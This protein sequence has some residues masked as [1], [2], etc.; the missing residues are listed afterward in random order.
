MVD[1]M[2][3]GDGIG[4]VRF[5]Q[6]AQVLQAVTALGPA[7]DPF[8]TSRLNTKNILG[9]PDLTPGGSTSIGDG[10]FEGR[11]ALDAA[12]SGFD[13]KALVVLTDGVENEPRWIADVAPQINSFTYSVGLGTPENTSA[14]ALQAIS[15]NH[16]GYLLVTGAISGD[17]RFILQK[18]FLQILAGISNADVVLDPQG[19][20]V[21]EHEQR[22]PFYLTEADS[23]VDVILLTDYP[24]IVDFRVETPMG[25]VIEPWRA[26]AEPGMLYSST[27]G[28]T[29]YRIALPV[30]LFPARFEQA[31]TWHALLRI[32]RPRTQRPDTGP[33]LSVPPR[34]LGIETPRRIVPRQMQPPPGVAPARDLLTSATATRGQRTLPYSLVVHSYSNLSFKCSLSQGSFEPGARV[35]LFASLAE[36]GVPAARGARVW[37]ELVRPDGSQ[38]VVAMTEQDAGQFSGTFATTLAGLYR[39]RVRVS[40]TSRAGHPF[41][42]EQMLTAGVWSGGDRDADPN[43]VNGGP[44]VQWLQDKDRRLCA[45]LHCLLAEGRALTPETE[46]RLAQAGID[47]NWLRRCLD[48]YC[49]AASSGT[50]S[51]VLERALTGG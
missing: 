41:R 1:V 34:Q 36:S 22:I 12:G 4:L 38:A 18:Y 19:E 16:G 9:G 48:Q 27:A 39:I 25:L 42:R 5:N 26:I 3:E 6:D 29:Y 46:R 8:D 24:Q 2:L 13:V 43:N 31:G 32:G 23:A 14:P 28:N 15:G 30:E 37:A 47:V 44:I 35:T 49:S 45:L 40:G 10:I 20:L 33:V 50:P 17:N 7:G 51:A 11:G 21:P